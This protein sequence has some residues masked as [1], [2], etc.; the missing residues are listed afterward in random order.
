VAG[1]AVVAGIVA[2]L[3]TLPGGQDDGINRP[4]AGESIGEILNGPGQPGTAPKPG[5]AAEFAPPS[6]PDATA[7]PGASVTVEPN[8][9][10]ATP[11]ESTPSFTSGTSMLPGS[12]PQVESI[13]SLEAGALRGDA[14]SQ[15]LLA[16]RYA[17]GRGVEKDDGKALSLVT[18]AAQQ[19]LVMAQ[20]RLGA[21][22]ERGIG[23]PKDLLQARGWY[24]R[25]AKGGNRK[26]MHNLAVLFADG[27]GI[28]QNFQQAAQWFR[29]GAEHGLS[30]SQYNLAVL[31][32]R[33]MGA[34]KNLS[35][36]AK[37]Y[38]IAASQGDAGAAEKLE[39][40]KKV[41]SASD[42]AMA[43][44]AA[45]QFKPKPLDKTANELPSVQG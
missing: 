44:E 28:G 15:L 18:K 17:E 38:A 10:G 4:G 34:D 7:A 29:Q 20:Y 36:A 31:L 37:W 3:F 26:A 19:G 5:P 2:L 39:G 13:A 9:L 16:L 27:V 35:E 25:A 8:G 24:E 43:L 6:S 21:M 22:Y 32:E 45:R 40:L 23:V 42:V 14:T 41:L 33:G 12:E 11:T 30:D 1:L